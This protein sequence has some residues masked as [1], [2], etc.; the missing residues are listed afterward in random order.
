ML[1]EALDDLVHPAGLDA[2]LI[3]SS[4][5]VQ[6]PYEVVAV[7]VLVALQVQRLAQIIS[8]TV[9]EAVFEVL[10]QNTTTFL[11]LRSCDSSLS[12]RSLYR[13]NVMVFVMFLTT[14]SG[15]NAVSTVF[16]SAKTKK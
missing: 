14:L 7:V 5:D 16:V 1:K 15:Q 3:H 9:V 4:D 12:N 10:S 11:K 2:K 13:L 8:R 6:V